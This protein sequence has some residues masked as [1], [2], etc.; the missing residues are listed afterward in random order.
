MNT[1]TQLLKTEEN[2]EIIKKSY[3][4]W[5]SEGK[6]HLFIDISIAYLNTQAL[7]IILIAEGPQIFE[8]AYST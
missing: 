7:K 5:K 8:N 3:E 1:L 6:Q 2:A 4:F